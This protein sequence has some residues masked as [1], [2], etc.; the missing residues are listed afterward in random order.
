MA[1]KKL[2][3][4]EGLEEYNIKWHERLQAMVIENDEVNDIFINE[5]MKNY[6]FQFVYDTFLGFS[7]Y[8][9]QYFSRYY[10]NRPSSWFYTSCDYNENMA[11]VPFSLYGSE[12]A[13]M[14]VNWGDGEQT[15]LRSTDFVNATE[16][17]NNIHYYRPI[18]YPDESIHTISITSSDWDKIYM[19][20][21]CKGNGTYWGNGELLEGLY[22]KESAQYI[23]YYA[24]DENELLPIGYINEIK[25]HNIQYIISMMRFGM[26]KIITPLPSLAGTI[27][28]DI[29]GDEY[30]DNPEIYQSVPAYG[31]I[32]QNKL[33]FILSYYQNLTS[34]PSNLFTYNKHIKSIEGAFWGTDSINFVG[35]EHMLEDCTDIENVSRCFLES[36]S[37]S[38]IWLS[39]NSITSAVDFSDDP[40]TVHLPVN[41]PSATAF[42]NESNVTIGV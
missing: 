37:P 28:G 24:P 7:K 42:Q 11:S 31:D 12:N 27:W 17:P 4:Y 41:S 26:L 15:I 33:S 6:T 1:E 2:L 21:G 16:C 40:I 39:S 13:S 36:A 14:T 30:G 29:V 20:G 10:M 22:N 23:Y 9:N 18:T 35:T 19:I 8:Y 38:E 32:L 5:I 25:T 3:T 34:I